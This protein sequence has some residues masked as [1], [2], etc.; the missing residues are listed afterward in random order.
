MHTLPLVGKNN[1][2]H[3]FGW[4]CLGLGRGFMLAG[5]RDGYLLLKYAVESTVFETNGIGTKM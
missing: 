4:N 1:L 5:R 3:I 2:T